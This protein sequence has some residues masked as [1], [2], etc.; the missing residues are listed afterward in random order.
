MIHYSRDQN[1]LAPVIDVGSDPVLISADVEQGSRL[2][3]PSGCNIRLPESRLG[4]LKVLPASLPCDPKP[5]LERFRM[6]ASFGFR[7]VE[8]FQLPSADDVHD[9]TLCEVG[10]QINAMQI[11]DGL[12]GIASQ[13]MIGAKGNSAR[14]RRH[15]A[16]RCSLCGGI[17]CYPFILR[18]EQPSRLV[19]TFGFG[20]LGRQSAAFGGDGAVGAVLEEHCGSLGVSQR[21]SNEQR[22]SLNVVLHID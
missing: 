1:R 2:A 13:L 10:Q 8:L 21:R 16:E 17:N 4:F 5:I 22:R 18:I 19:M 11:V 9:F 14:N 15:G 7:L 12:E 6:S 3:S 20:D